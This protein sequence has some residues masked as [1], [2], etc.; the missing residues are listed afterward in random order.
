[1]IAPARK[2]SIRSFDFDPQRLTEAL[3]MEHVEHWFEPVARPS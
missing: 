3:E 2:L 1:V